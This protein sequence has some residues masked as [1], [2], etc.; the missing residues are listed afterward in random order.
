MDRGD[1]QSLLTLQ[2]ARLSTT[3]Q[4]DTFH[5]QPV[6]PHGYVARALT[7]LFC[8]HF[9]TD[10]SCRTGV[11]ATVATNKTKIDTF[12]ATGLAANPTAKCPIGPIE[13][14]RRN[15][16]PDQGAIRNAWS[17]FERRA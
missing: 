13:S 5:L 9:N 1:C 14:L 12:G 17:V 6:I 15:K 4:R 10:P 11:L 7:T 2:S 3:L 8:G 16:P